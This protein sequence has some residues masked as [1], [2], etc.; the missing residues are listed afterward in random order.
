MTYWQ[1]WPGVPPPEGEPLGWDS[2]Y[3]TPVGPLTMG[4][5]TAADAEIGTGVVAPTWPPAVGVQEFGL[6]PPAPDAKAGGA[7]AISSRAAP[8]TVASCASPPLFIAVGVEGTSSRASTSRTMAGSLAW[9]C[10]LPPAEAVHDVVVDQ[11]ACLHQ[12]V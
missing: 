8:A 3:A 1:G 6:A 12:R 10:E 4:Q 7:G 9:A 2:P 5:E 11:P